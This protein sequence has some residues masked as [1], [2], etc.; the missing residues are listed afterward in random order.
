[1]GRGAC[2]RRR[3]LEAVVSHSRL[4]SP[5]GSSR[6]HSVPIHSDMAPQRLAGRAVRSA[7]AALIMASLPCALAIGGP[8]AVD[9]PVEVFVTRVQLTHGRIEYRYTVANGGALPITTLLIGF[10][11]YYSRPCLYREPIG[12]DGDTIPASS[13]RSPPGW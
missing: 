5:E 3:P 10:D 9:R 8:K 1:M 12:W 4:F 6:G 2:D 13:F 7:L 11:E